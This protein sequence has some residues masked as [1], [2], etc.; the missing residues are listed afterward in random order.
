MAE[1]PQWILALLPAESKRGR[2]TQEIVGAMA[3][4]PMKPMRKPMRPEKPTSIW[5]QEVTMT[6][7][8][9]LRGEVFRTVGLS[10][11]QATVTVW[12][13]AAPQC[14]PGQPNSPGCCSPW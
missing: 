12:D 11:A 2:A 10:A 13:A 4:G 7:P 6:A 8:C 1:I 14:G 3:K 5:T 9:N